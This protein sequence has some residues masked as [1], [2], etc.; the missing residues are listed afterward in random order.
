MSQSAARTLLLID[1]D[2]PWRRLLSDALRRRGV[3]VWAAAGGDEA[4]ALLAS[5]ALRAAGAPRWVVC[6]LKMPE[7]DGIE[8][9][10]PLRD[11]LTR[12]HALSS[13][14]PAPEPLI[15]I[16]TGYGS[17]ASAVQALKLGASHMMMKPVG[18]DALIATFERLEGER[19]EGE[20]L[21][22]ER[23]EGERLEG[24]RLLPHSAALE[25][26][27]LAR[28]EWEHIQR[29]LTEHD[30]NISRAARA[31]GLHRRTLQRKLQTLPPLR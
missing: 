22:G 19:L 7:R 8:L 29:V 5:P 1:D 15:L 18:V 6:D 26:P 31:L 4:L 13:A 24:E 14:G 30:N 20:R 28:V 21:E 17:V 10:A 27:S 23:L 3:E 11:A 2:A 9:L 25:A 12:A 16:L